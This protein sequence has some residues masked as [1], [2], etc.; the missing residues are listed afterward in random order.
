MKKVYIIPVALAALILPR[1]IRAE[2]GDLDTVNDINVTAQGV[3]N[4]ASLTDNDAATAATL[5]TGKYIVWQCPV[6]YIVRSYTLTGS[7]DATKNPRT[8]V[9]EGSTDGLVWTQIDRKSAQNVA[10]GALRTVNITEA[11]QMPYRYFRFMVEQVKDG[12]TQ[13]NLAELHL[14]GER[15]VVPDAPTD[16]RVRSVGGSVEL[17]WR[18]NADN[19]TGYLVERSFN[20][21]NWTTLATLPA[22][23]TRFTD[24][25]LPAGPGAIYRVSARLNSVGSDYLSSGVVTNDGLAALTDVALN[26]GGSATG[27]TPI[28]ASENGA[29]AFD[30]DVATKYLSTALPATLTI[31]LPEPVAVEQYAVVS[32]N[33]APG[34]DPKTWV[35]EA[36][37]NGT[38]WT[39]LDRKDGQTFGS[40]FQTNRYAIANTTPY[41][42]YRLRVTANNG[43]NL[44]QFAELALYADIPARSKD[45]ALVAPTGVK[46][47]VRTYNQVEVMWT[48]NNSGE[49]CYVVQ[50]SNDGENWTRDYTTRPNDTACYPY[51][52]KPET[53]YYFRVAAKAGE[54]LGPWSEVATCTTPNDEWPETWPNFNFDNGYHTG[55]LVCKYSNDDIAIFVNPADVNAEGK[56]ML[57]LDLSWMYEP[58][59]KMWVAIRETYKDSYG[60]YLVS[61]PKLYIVPHYHAD[62]G[63]LGRLF[64]YRD[65]DQLFRNIVHI[66]VGKNSGWRWENNP[67]N[68][69]TNFLYDV[70]THEIGH[71]IEGIGSGKKN[72]PF[73]AVWLDSKWA[74]I[75]QY[76]IFGK[77]DPYH[78]QVWHREYMQLG[79]HAEQK[80]APG[81]EWYAKWLYPTY[82]DFG[83][84]QLF[85]RFFALLGEHYAQRNGEL[86]GNGNLGEYVHFMSGAAGH[87]VTAYAKDAFG[88]CDEWELQLTEARR[89]YSAVTYEPAPTYL[90]LITRASAEVTT[91]APGAASIDKL[92]DDNT[93]TEFDSATKNTDIETVEI[94]YRD[95]LSS[96]SVDK[97]IIAVGSNKTARPTSIALLGSHDGKEWSEIFADADPEYST[98]GTYERSL[99]EAA[100]YTYFKLS[101][102]VYKSKYQSLKVSEWQLMGELLPA[103]PSDLRGEWNGNAGVTITWSAPYKGIDRFEIERSTAGGEFAKVG[104]TDV[105]TLSF[106]DTDALPGTTYSYR[107]REI[108]ADF[109]SP[110]SEV[111]TVSTSQSGV[112]AVE[113]TP[114]TV[115]AMLDASEDANAVTFRNLAGAA[116]FRETNIG[117]ARW[118]AL[119]S[120]ASELAPGVYIATV[121]IAGAQ[122]VH[123]KVAVK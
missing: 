23:S 120:G 57:D 31:T 95:P 61:D 92:R 82:R 88:W 52:L 69:S 80:P 107:V 119:C 106:T 9:L 116:V 26:L 2:V 3:A 105:M 13:C 14:Q 15:L 77:M 66:S 102:G 84:D 48:D 54:K 89:R 103:I 110:Y 51:A 98:E 7:S 4:I 28:N 72:S 108:G 16:I 18:D 34:R 76:D 70:T 30:G 67:G 74:E 94:T 53:T 22:N 5:T 78:Q 39:E 79:K 21:F 42:Q 109:T 91:N 63:G 44:T 96:A 35:L 60:E 118:Q 37:N 122:P 83:G 97:C 40:R 86:L 33:D 113:A 46:L 17:A 121:K 8:W 87:D 81:A 93:S 117:A 47:N 10:A 11:K 112:Q 32:A 115:G 6:A 36:S 85:L 62:G 71:I 43:D 65:Q 100:Q 1:A 12:G 25:N 58:Y 50:R 111:L 29:K 59:T 114:A 55:N 27:T 24:T 56:S 99:A 101:L 90:N 20:G 104:E 19:E 49:D 68:G 38:Q 64:Q 73:Y 41:S 123:I 45:V 75:F